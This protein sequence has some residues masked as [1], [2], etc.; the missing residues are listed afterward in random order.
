MPRDASAADVKKAFR[1]LAKKLHPDANKH[2]PQA[3]SQFAE[4]NAAYEIIG[5]ADKRKAFDRGEIDAEGKPRYQGFEGFGAGAGPGAGR[6]AGGFS[7]F[8]RDGG[9]ETYTY[10]P[11]GFH[12]AGGGG[13]PEG[14]A[15]FEDILKDVFGGLGGGGGGRRRQRAHFETDDFQQMGPGQ[16]ATAAVTVTLEEAAKGTKRRVQL[17][18]GKELEVKIPAGLTSGKQVRLKG[19]GFA[20][21]GGRSGDAIIT[22]LIAPKSDFRTAGRRPA[23]RSGGHAL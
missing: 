21:A 23:D 15:G 9:F 19:Q 5:D 22:V 20:G 4:L 7:G 11:D 17:P 10:G 12:R 2:D 8:S 1:K 16:D 3:A 14:A 18:T 6:G 13:G